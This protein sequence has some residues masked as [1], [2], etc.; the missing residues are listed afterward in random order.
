MRFAVV[1]CAIAVSACG[2]TAGEDDP[3][4]TVAGDDGAIDGDD[5]AVSL[6]SAATDDSAIDSA[7]A[8]SAK[9]E[10][11]PDTRMDAPTIDTGKALCDGFS[12]LP[13][14]VPDKCDGPSGTTTT[15][16]PVNRIYATSW[17]G[18]YRKTDGTIYKDPTDNCLFA[19]GNKGLC[20]SGLSGPECEATLQW[21]AANSDRY[22]CGSR[23]RVTN[24]LNGKAVVLVTLDRGPNC[25]TVEKA[26]GAPVVD[27][28]HPAMIYLFDG[29]VYGGSDKKRVIVE[30]VDITTPLGP[31]K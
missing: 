23:I 24:C 30:K 15:E 25:N 22:G 21:F 28:S 27:M 20:A 10:T 11:A 7:E 6:D 9:A 31:V 16:I 4:F 13:F 29:K 14:D 17:F 12:T 2:G 19:C 8:D 3:P 1:L 26:Y 5:T 18:C